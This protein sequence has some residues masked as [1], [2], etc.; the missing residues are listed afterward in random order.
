MPQGGWESAPDCIQHGVPGA[1]GVYKPYEKCTDFFTFG[2]GS[3]FGTFSDGVATSYWILVAIGFTVMLVFLV[4]WV[5][6][7]DRKLKAQAAYLLRGGI[8]V[9]AVGPTGSTEA[10]PDVTRGA[11]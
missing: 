4:W 9:S 5:V 2:P 10:S 6:L 8:G 1:D 3:K 7:E 11:E